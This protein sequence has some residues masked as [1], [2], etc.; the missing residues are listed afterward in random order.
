MLKERCNMQQLTLQFEGYADQA[1]QPIDA[2]T[3]RQC[4]VVSDPA[5]RIKSAA[6]GLTVR[7]RRI[8]SPWVDAWQ[9]WAAKR[10]ETFTALCGSEGDVF[11]HGD[12]V[13]AHL[14]LALLF[15][16]IG[17]GGAA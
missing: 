12:V 10:S 9:A 15:T 3:A 14:W 4:N 7:A 8:V 11:T 13:K 1:Q 2:G 16:L 5:A 6:Y 17:I